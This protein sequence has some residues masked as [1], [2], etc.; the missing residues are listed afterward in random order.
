MEPRR[1]VKELVDM[2]SDFCRALDAQPPAYSY[3]PLS[4]DE[5]RVRVMKSRLFN[6]QRAA[7]LFGGWL[8]T[9]PE[10]EVRAVLAESAHEEMEHAQL[11]ANRIRQLGGD[12]FDYHPLPAQV[13]MFNA[14][15]GLPDTVQR[16]A[17]FSLAGE[18]VAT[19]LIRKMLD[20]PSVPNWIKEPY[21]RITQDEEGHASMPQEMLNR[22]AITPAQ[23][24][25]AR[26][27][28]AMRL[29]LFQ[30]YLASLDRWALGQSDW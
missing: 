1:F 6:E 20:A 10:F 11:L 3:I 4:S 14:M 8:K 25:A 7:D 24:D 13:A 28:V 2:V 22:Y 9:T 27:A 30:A 16:I 19:Y 18:S 29:I 12:P 15:E 26:R 5:Q 21:R 17:G 23:Q